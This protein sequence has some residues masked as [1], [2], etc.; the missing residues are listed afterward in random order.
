M[1]EKRLRIAASAFLV[2]ALSAPS[3]LAQSNTHLSEA[4]RAYAAVDY[5]ATRTAAKAALAQGGNDLATTSELYLL[6]GTAAAALDQ[7]EEARTAFSH[8]L[9]ANPGLKLDRDLSPKIRAPYQEARGNA[10]TA[11]GKPPLEIGLT[12]RRQELELTLRDQ[13][14]VAASIELWARE[15]DPQEFTRRR[16]DAARVRRVPLPSGQALQYFL[17][18]LDRQGNVLFEAGTSEEP[19]RLALDSAPS[20]PTTT[21]PASKDVNRTPYYITAG[22]LA[23]LGL[24][25]GGVATAMYL[26]RED[27][28]KDWNGPSC[29]QPGGTRREQC[30]SVEDRRQTAQNLAIGFTAGGGALLLGSLVTLLIA[31]SSSTSDTKVVVDASPQSVMFQL[32]TTL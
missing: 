10:T 7:A 17:R 11:S 25:A 9:A 27:A 18:V 2:L 23:A 12:R 4:Q 15:R 24:A 22:G 28:A 5:E 3:A 32:G 1:N 13:L 14:H 31:P 21:P 30:G 16:F 6:W 19:R 8:A 26:R 29:E 20:T